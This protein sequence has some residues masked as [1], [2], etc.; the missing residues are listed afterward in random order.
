M[1]ANVGTLIREWRKR[2][3]LTQIDLSVEA[4]LSTRHLSF[5]ETGRAQPGRETL[6]RIAEALDMPLDERNIMFNAAGFAGAHSAHELQDAASGKRTEPARGCSS[7]AAACCSRS[8]P[9]RQPISMHAL[10]VT[11]AR[12][13]ATATAARAISKCGDRRHGARRPVVHVF[14]KHAGRSFRRDAAPTVTK[15]ARWR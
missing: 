11:D 5:L 6:G 3:G 13:N 7:R 14:L 1:Q 15:A 10:R 4:A 12:W 8:T 9:A 2:R